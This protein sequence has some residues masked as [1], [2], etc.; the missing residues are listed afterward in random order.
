MPV[1]AWYGPVDA[2]G[3]QRLLIP[4]SSLLIDGFLLFFGGLEGEFLT[5]GA[6]AVG[7]LGTPLV[8]FAYR[9][10]QSAINRLPACPE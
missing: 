10:R 4:V 5:T 6:A 2:F 3:L 8:E 1:R 9:L 7:M